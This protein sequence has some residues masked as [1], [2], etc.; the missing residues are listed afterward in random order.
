MSQGAVI[1][2]KRTKPPE[3]ACT[4]AECGDISVSFFIVQLFFNVSNTTKLR[5]QSLDVT[6]HWGLLELRPRQVYTIV[7]QVCTIPWNELLRWRKQP[8][9]PRPFSHLKRNGCIKILFK[10]KTEDNCTLYN[11][12][13]RKQPQ[14]RCIFCYWEQLFCHKWIPYGKL[15]VRLFLARA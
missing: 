12:L 6:R 7:S 2:R 3:I 5:I 4:A 1:D 14:W 15:E 10:P 11:I 8:N 13:R 9:F